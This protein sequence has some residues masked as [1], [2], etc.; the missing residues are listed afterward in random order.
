MLSFFLLPKG[1]LNKLDY[2]RS[3]F[4]WQEDSEK[5]KY[6]FAKWNVVCHPND[7]GGIGIL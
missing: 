2:Y 7:Q 1:I 6:Q 5:K 4:Y 3:R